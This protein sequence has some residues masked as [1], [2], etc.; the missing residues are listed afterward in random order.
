MRF[1]IRPEFC[2]GKELLAPFSVERLFYEFSFALEANL[3]LLHAI[4]ESDCSRL[5]IT[6]FTLDKETWR[7]HLLRVLC[8]ALKIL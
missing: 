3:F 5:G 2:I 8:D 4:G 6:F 1:P 7:A